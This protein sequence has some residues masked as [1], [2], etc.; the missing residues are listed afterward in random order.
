MAILRR[1]RRA[2]IPIL[3]VLVIAGLVFLA[4]FL[5][6]GSQ[7]PTSTVYTVQRGNISAVARALGK[8]RVQIRRWCRRWGLDPDAF[9]ERS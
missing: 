4:S 7:A 5:L 9:R 2:G 6:A 8:E 3:I 1:A